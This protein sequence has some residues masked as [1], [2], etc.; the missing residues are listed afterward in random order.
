MEPVLVD[1]P[2]F[3]GEERGVRW[4]KMSLRFRI[5]L[6]VGLFLAI[7]IAGVS[8]TSSNLILRSFVDLEHHDSL[9]HL[10]RADRSFEEME[11]NL[12]VKSVDWSSWD[13]CYRF[14]AD[15][16]Q[17][18]VTSNVIPSALT[19]LKLDVFV[20]AT[21]K[22]RVFK[23]LTVPRKQNGPSPNATELA[24]KLNFSL[25]RHQGRISKS[26][27]SGFVQLSTGTMLVSVRPIL[28][29][30]DTGPSRGWL[31][32]GRIFAEREL[33]E[34]RDLTRLNLSVTPFGDPSLAASKT[35]HQG[36][37]L[38]DV[39]APIDEKTMGGHSA[40]RDLYG[41]P[42]LLLS[43]QK[44]REI[45]RQ[46]LQGV[47]QLQN[48]IL[49][50]GLLFGAVIVFVLE[51]FV[52]SRLVS[53]SAEVAEIGDLPE[54][55]QVSVTGR[56]EISWLATKINET[57]SQL[58]ETELRLQ[59]YNTNLEQTVL[60]RTQEIEYQAFHD[61]LTGLANRTLFANRLGNVLRKAERSNFSIAVFHINLD[62][63]KLFNDS[64]GH[65][66]GDAILAEVAKRLT[67]AARPGDTVARLG[68]D[69]FTILLEGLTR[70]KEAIAVSKLVLQKL[71]APISAAGHE[72][73]ANASI[74]IAYTGD[75]SINF[76]QLMRNAATAM[77]RA[78]EAGKSN[79]VVYHE[80]MNDHAVERLE[81]EN[82]IRKAAEKGEIHVRYQPLI[83]L[84]TG[85]MKGVEALARWNH[86]TK[87]AISP[88]RFIPIAEETGIIVPLGYWI[89]EEACRQAAEW[90]N[91]FDLEAF[92]VSINLS[93]KQLQRDDV[94]DRVAEILYITGLAPHALKLEITES[95]LM[96]DRAAVVEKMR[97]LKELGIKLALDDF[98]TGY[99]SLST[100]GSFPVDT[101]K[102]DQSF[103]SRLGEEEEA[104]SIVQAIISLSCSMKMDVTGEGVE[105]EV[106]RQLITGL[107]CHTGQG[108]LFDPPLTPTD[109]A[110]RL[111]E[112]RAYVDPEES[113]VAA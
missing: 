109:L 50:A 22:G 73:F 1:T 106:Q 14:M 38:E 36:S 5:L 108:Y 12:H 64:W 107:G 86:P 74:G 23:S 7:L 85:T 96:S 92:T 99:S 68:G 35:A 83:D 80:S 111:R 76:D 61:K 11:S 84:A 46:G 65:Q 25:L 15:G 79:F 89:M 41:Q 113:R 67:D 9:E 29:S 48:V 3:F 10:A 43:M 6:S 18:F 19:Q 82:G 104:A 13:D 90:R 30:D 60:E 21:P 54:K 77:Y 63:F 2:Y 4:E 26:G 57:L 69:E 59:S 95:V 62:N 34:L 97:L 27:I 32:F 103:V 16:N 87:G 98:G 55:H 53:L 39:V 20:F 88:G 8:L 52:L 100:L 51:R 47:G 72:A 33:A 81:I 75:A 105:T 42:S 110:Q 49:I 40:L 93:G 101:L 44:P 66:V 102:I 91:E 31:V 70:E 17:E 56:D 24:K 71:R 45:Y 37:A 28:R 78:K 58:H 94:V 112:R